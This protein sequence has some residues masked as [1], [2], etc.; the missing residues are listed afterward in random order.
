[1]TEI[2]G[3]H[4]APRDGKVRSVHSHRVQN[5]KAGEKLPGDDDSVYELGLLR[6]GEFVPKDG[7]WVQRPSGAE[8][9][10]EEGSKFPDGDAE[11]DFIWAREK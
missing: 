4:T 2:L 10:R 6:C 9:F 11:D 7:V 5:V 3:G 1:M 8:A